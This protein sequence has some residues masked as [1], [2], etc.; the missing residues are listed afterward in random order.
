MSSKKKFSI[1]EQIAE[2]KQFMFIKEKLIHMLQFYKRNKN[3]K[4][5]NENDNEE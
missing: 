1:I 5:D 2:R 4:D 3:T